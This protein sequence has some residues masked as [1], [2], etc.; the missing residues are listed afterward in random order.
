[1]FIFWLHEAEML[2]KKIVDGKYEIGNVVISHLSCSKS[3]MN[4]FIVA[5]HCSLEVTEPTKKTP[6]CCFTKEQ[7][8]YSMF[9]FLMEVEN[10]EVTQN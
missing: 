2:R 1:M 10:S 5:F 6:V 3:P 8:Y 4:L 7:L 9:F